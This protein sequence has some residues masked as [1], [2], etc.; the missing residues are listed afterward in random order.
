MVKFVIKSDAKKSLEEN[1]ISEIKILLAGCNTQN[2]EIKLNKLLEMILKK[3][4]I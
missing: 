1:F 3:N 4:R 2:R